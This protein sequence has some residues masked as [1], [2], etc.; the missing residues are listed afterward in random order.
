M[1]SHY[2]QAVCNHVKNPSNG[3]AAVKSV[4]GSGKTYTAIEAAKEINNFYSVLMAA[5]NTDIRDEF[6]KRLEEANL[7]HVASK[8]FNGFGLGI[9][10][11]YGNPIHNPDK[12][13]NILESLLKKD[14][15]KFHKYKNPVK[16]II[17]LFKNSNIHTLDEASNRFDEI[18]EHF[19]LEIPNQKEDEDFQDLTLRVFQA[20]LNDIKTLDFDDQKFMPLQLGYNIPKFDYVIVDEFQDVCPV[21]FELL[22]RACGEMFIALGDEDQSIYGFK[23]ATPD[24]F[25]TTIQKMRMK[26]LP[27]SICYRC[28]I[29]VIKEAQSLVPR[30]ESAPGAIQGSVDTVQ[31]SIFYDQVQGRDFVL[32]RTSEPL[33]KECLLNLRK[34][35]K[36]K[37]RGREIG[38]NSIYLIDKI[39]RNQDGMKIVDFLPLLNSYQIECRDLLLAAR[40][41]DA[42]LAFDDRVNT[43]RVFCEE[44]STLSDVKKAISSLCVD[45]NK[46]HDGID[47]MTAHKSKGLQAENVWI[48]RPDLMPHYRAKKPWMKKQEINLKYVAITRATKNLRYVLKDKDER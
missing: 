31:K 10:Y 29:S 48:L 13:I 7:R 5:F 35:K 45:D 12:T 2:Q 3:H 6:K 37:I 30:I 21:E 1:R 15:K 43:V 23:G 22:S 24:I 41:E 18:V 32:C 19:N 39:S 36:G 47:Y 44:G 9:C 11:K 42:A 40:K 34:G 20:S 38:S 17:S 16:Q 46:K 4:A 26:E 27:L 28:P 25:P 33:V 8:N 14:V